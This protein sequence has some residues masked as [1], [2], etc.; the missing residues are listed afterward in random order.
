M[1][2]PERIRL[3]NLPTRIDELKRFNEKYKRPGGPKVYIKRDDL[4]GMETSGNKIRKLE[5]CV[6]DALN[7]GCTCLITCGA[8]QSNHCR[9]TAA[10]A[11]SLGLKACLV[12]GG[13]PDAAPDGNYL[14]DRLLGAEIH[15]IDPER[16][17]D[18][19]EIMRKLAGEIADKGGKAY[20]IPA[21]ASN[22]I[23]VFGYYTAMEEILKQ[24]KEMGVHFDCI[25]VTAGSAGT[26]SG[27]YM[28]NRIEKN[29]ADIIGFSVGG[30]SASVTE[31]V[32]AIIDEG[33]RYWNGGAGVPRD[34][35]HI[36]DRYVGLG[37]GLSRPEELAFIREFA[38]LEG[39]V[40]SPV[41]TGKAMYGLSEEIKRGALDRYQNVLFIHTGGVFDVFPQKDKFILDE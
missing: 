8:V 11:A 36:I 9:A 6:K 20:V 26:Y 13:D 30:D 16:F 15:I 7:Q 37:Y 10:V 4:S 32:N 2:L 19:D 23:G 22:G 41:Y 28:A 14:L 12:L 18:R 27:L 25:V 3:A 5:Y 35:I 17:D 34:N 33:L 24:E 1:K 40:L 31:N 29:D 21:G 39:I 38:S